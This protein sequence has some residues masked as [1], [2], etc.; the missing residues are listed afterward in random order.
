[1]LNDITLGQFFPGDSV[2][3]K[4]DPRMK[5]IL[6]LL[7]IT[8]VFFANNYY[9][10]ALLVAGALIIAAVSQLSVMMLLKGLKPIIFIAVFTAVIN[11]F[12]TKGENLIFE[13]WI[14]R[15]YDDGLKMALFMVLRIIT[16]I[17]GTGVLLTYTTSPMALTDAI[18]R[19]L[20]PLKKLHVPV[21]EFAMMMT[22]AL[23]FIPTLIEETEKITNAQ[24][25]RGADFESGKLIDRA[26]AMIP[27]LIP[28]FVSAFRRADELAV[29]MECRLYHGGEGRTRMK[30]LKL[31]GRDF[32]ALA[33]MIT[34]SAG[35]LILNK[36]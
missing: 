23:R 11:I 31:S 6:M 36:L 27:I 5:I 34:F 22:I 18:E 20:S 8:S 14:I 2:L 3:H 21:H 33:M 13:F 9:S 25:A 17:L 24:K 32:T 19:L 15:I 12:W 35:L 7:F 28:L 30:V 16:L 1:M 26:K 4:I 29:A 10:F